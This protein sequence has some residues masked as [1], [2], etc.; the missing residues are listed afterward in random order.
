MV[1]FNFN[2]FQ[3]DPEGGGGVIGPGR[4][5]AVI[6]ETAMKPT[7]ANDG[8]IL[9]IT[10]RVAQGPN[11]GRK[12]T[13]TFNVQNKNPTAVQ[14]AMNELAAI[15]I[16]CGVPQIADT[17]Q[18][19]GRPLIIDVTV[20]ERADGKG[21]ANRIAGYFDVNGQAPTKGAQQ[22][23]PAG[24]QPQQQTPPPQ[25]PAPQTPP[26]GAPAGQAPW[27]G[28]PAAGPAPWDNAQ[29][30]ADGA[31]PWQQAP[32]GGSTPPWQQPQG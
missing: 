9:S 32:A 12:L 20:E 15:G 17:A 26:Q 2:A 24:F 31:A 13:E 25:Q 11:T 23:A 29:Q 5:P 21:Q 14:I 3:H 27:Q 30:P 19:H 10:F 28:Q 22:G 8:T 1:A 4:Y 6:H 18:W 7:K 16:A